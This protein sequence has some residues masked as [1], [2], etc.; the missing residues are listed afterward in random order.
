M[1]RRVLGNTGEEI[2]ILGLGGIVINNMPQEESNRIVSEAVDRGVTYFDVAPDYDDAQE[3]LGPALEPYREKVFLAC[4][5]ERWDAE[6]CARELEESLRLLRTD[7]IDLYQ[8]HGLCSHEDVEEVLGP[9]GAI[10]TFEAARRDGKVRYLGFSSHTVEGAQ[11]A[12]ARYEGWNSILFPVNFV[13]W[14]D[15]FGPQVVEDARN[16]GVAR[17]ALKSIARTKWPGRENRK[18]P[19]CWYEPFDDRDQAA[20]AFRFTLSQDVTAA[21]TPGDPALFPMMLDL[22]DDFHPIT[23]EETARLHQMTKGLT[24][25]F[26]EKG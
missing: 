9:G 6:G 21:V 26:P 17:L 25:V 24:P 18:Y 5:T 12:L 16:R 8:F 19:K 22:A 2:S 11:E 4:K 20:L 23:A 13:C 1:K 7:R 10:E 3:R 15:G 14:R